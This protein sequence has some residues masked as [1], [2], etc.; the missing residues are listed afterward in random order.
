MLTNPYHHQELL[1]KISEEGILTGR[2][3]REE[4]G[5]GQREHHGPRMQRHLVVGHTGQVVVDSDPQLD[6][7]QEVGHRDMPLVDG[8][9][10]RVAGLGIRVAVLGIRVAVL[11][12]L[13]AGQDIR[14]A[15]R[16]IR[17]RDNLVDLDILR[18]VDERPWD[19]PC[20]LYLP[21]CLPSWEGPNGDH[22]AKVAM[23]HG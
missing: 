21:S 23:S 16:G 3:R 10:I 17:V 1:P 5:R 8:P 22:P 20:L 13:V 9:G 2:H 7:H 19:N 15:D 11:G 14:V 4:L 6:I 18:V 12:T